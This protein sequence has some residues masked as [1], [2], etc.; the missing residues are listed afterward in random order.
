VISYLAALLAAVTNA[1]S[2]ALNR[3]AAREAPGRDQ[4]RLRLISDLLHRK[5]WLA[6]ISL[7][8]LSFVFSAVALGTGQLAAVQLLII[9]ELPMT[10]IIGARIL[11][12]HIT[13][14]EWAGTAA[15]TAGVIGLLVRLDPR[16]GPS[17]AVG[18]MQWI[19][20]PRSARAS[21]E[22]CSWRHGRAAARHGR[23]R[24]SGP[25]RGSGTG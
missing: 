25:P 21:S 11:H 1:T 17:R 15:M 6:A 13:A 12:V 24:C 22:S 2:N 9:L 14:Q 3:K 7:M 8:F 10:L 18:P 19:L 23:R 20:A 4:F 5:A 16:P